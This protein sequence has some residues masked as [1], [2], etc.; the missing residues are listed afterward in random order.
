MDQN[1]GIWIDHKRAVIVRASATAVTTETV[2]S[3]VGAH[4]HFGGQQDGGGEKK[5]E[6]RHGQQLDRYYDDVIGHLA[7]PERLLIV[8]PGEAKGELA[9]RFRRSKAHVGCVVDVETADKLTDAEIVARVKQHFG[10]ER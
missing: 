1:V 9:Q 6:E 2:E 8:G 5:Y 3:N 4:P 7:G 10:I